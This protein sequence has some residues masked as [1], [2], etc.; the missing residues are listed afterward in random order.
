M[1]GMHFAP[2][3]NVGVIQLANRYIG[4]WYAWHRYVGIQDELFRLA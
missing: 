1:T 2:A 3:G 4:G